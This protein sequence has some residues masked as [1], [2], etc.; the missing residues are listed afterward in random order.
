MPYAQAGQIR[1]IAVSGPE[2][3]ESLPDVA[4][5]VEQGVKNYGTSGFTAVMAPAGTSAED[6]E[7][8]N[9]VIKEVVGSDTFQQRISALGVIPATSTPD[10]L[11][12]RIRD[13]NQAFQGMIDQV[14][15]KPQ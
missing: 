2:R 15:F 12:N 10:E 4:T 5:Y 8:F 14:G 1:I 3:L 6:I 13:T 9:A 7:R 11:T